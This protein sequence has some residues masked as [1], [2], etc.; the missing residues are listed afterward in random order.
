MSKSLNFDMCHVH[1]ITDDTSSSSRD[2]F[3]FIKTRIIILIYYNHK[4]IQKY[5]D[6]YFKITIIIL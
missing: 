2:H 1:E 4:I 3:L 5:D 6:Y